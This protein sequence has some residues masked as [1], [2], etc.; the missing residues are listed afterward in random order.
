MILNKISNMK[1]AFCEQS[2]VEQLL[3][4]KLCLNTS[5]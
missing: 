3:S 1:T 4:K 5:L 2:A